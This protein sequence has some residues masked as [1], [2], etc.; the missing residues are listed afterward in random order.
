M[1]TEKYSIIQIIDQL[2]V[3]GAERVL[4]TLS[5]LFHEHGHAVTVLTTVR[6]GPL[7]SL[8]NN[9][10]QQITLNRKWKWNPITMYRLYKAVK[11]YDIIHV[12]SSYN[13]RYLYCAKK[14]YSLRKLIF[15]HEHFGDI[16]LDKSV[17]W[18]QKLIYPNIVFIGVSR[19]H[20]K[21]ALD[22]LCM[23]PNRIFLL[24][25]TVRKEVVLSDIKNE[26]TTKQIIVVAN[27]RPSK[28]IEF[29]LKL[30]KTLIKGNK[31]KYHFTIIGQVADANYYNSILLL[32]NKYALD[33]Y[34]TIYHN[35]NQLQPHL[36]KYDRAIHTAVSESGPLVLI[37]YLAQGLP[38]LSYKTGEVA[39]MVQKELPEFILN[40]FEIDEWVN[41]MEHILAQPKNEWKAMLSGLYEK[42]FSTEV[43]YQKCLS[44]YEQALS[45]SISSK[46]F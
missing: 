25:N 28:N 17:K 1:H 42:H 20:T 24:P 4:V 8:L 46:E 38:F 10:I 31:H 43:Y 34:L 23:N 19:L 40:T 2:N 27:F 21:W 11:A 6:P 3:G 44:I 12:H 32:I 14:I 35:L 29:A 13:L 36:P 41:N 45:K 16:D 5:N 15:F 9:G 22:S 30:F 18:H 37:E 26:T 7:A 39:L 33:E